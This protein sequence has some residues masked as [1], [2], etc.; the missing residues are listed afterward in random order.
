MG[1]SVWVNE[2]ELNAPHELRYIYT[3]L[4]WN[5]QPSYAKNLK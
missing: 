4:F 3:G 1:N 5:N 2:L